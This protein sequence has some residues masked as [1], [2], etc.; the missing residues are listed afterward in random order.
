MIYEIDYLPR[1]RESGHDGLV[2]LK[3]YMDYFQ[4]IAAGQYHI[5]DKDN[6]TIH[7]KYG[8][9]WVYAKYRL[10]IYDRTDFD[11]DVHIAAWISRLDKVRSWQEMEVR[12]GDQLL[13]EGRLESCLIDLDDLSIAL[14]PRIELPE[15]LVVDRMTGAGQFRRR[16]A[17][18]ADA[19][20]CYTHTV[21]YSEIDNNRHM[22]NLHYVDMFMNAFD[23][24]FY[25]RHRITEFEIHYLRQAYWGD[26]LRIVCENQGDEYRLAALNSE[27]QAVAVCALKVIVNETV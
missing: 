17:V 18:S 15:G 14:I 24:D 19:A 22:N 16:L 2:G 12:R 4:D 25:D 9:A 27:D 3:G 21:R 1:F 8:V 26:A 20:Y 13:C 7:E 11:H 5:L 6:S 23:V 10:K